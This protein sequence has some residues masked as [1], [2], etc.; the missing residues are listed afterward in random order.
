MSDAHKHGVTNYLQ[1]IN[2]QTSTFSHLFS[3]SSTD[4][5]PELLQLLNNAGSTA[6]DQPRAAPRAADGDSGNL[7][8]QLRWNRTLKTIKLF[9]SSS[10][11]S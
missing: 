9:L 10:C 2:V 8:R 5:H 7:I 3:T 4:F 11:L 6:M 1:D